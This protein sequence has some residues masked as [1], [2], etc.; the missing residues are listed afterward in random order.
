MTWK[1]WQARKLSIHVMDSSIFIQERHPNKNA[2]IRCNEIAFVEIRQ[3][4]FGRLFDYGRVFVF[5]K[6]S[7]VYIFPFLISNPRTFR[8]FLYKVRFVFIRGDEKVYER[9]SKQMPTIK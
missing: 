2:I 5:K 7:T 1:F 8:K 3:N 6:D 4:L 9:I